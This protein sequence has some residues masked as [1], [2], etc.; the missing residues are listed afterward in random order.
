MHTTLVVGVRARSMHILHTLL[1]FV[2]RNI[3]TT[4][5]ASR[6]HRTDS[7]SIILVV[8]ALILCEDVMYELVRNTTSSSNMRSTYIHITV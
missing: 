8:Q 2:V 6:S 5:L 1:Y 3:H 7:D 4:T